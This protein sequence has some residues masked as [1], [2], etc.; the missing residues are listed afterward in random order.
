MSARR[1]DAS[2]RPHHPLVV[3]QPEP[4]AN[5]QFLGAPATG[6]AVNKDGQHAAI[7]IS[8]ARP[9]SRGQGPSV[10]TWQAEEAAAAR[11]SDQ[12]GGPVSASA[13]SKVGGAPL[14]PKGIAPAAAVQESIDQQGSVR[15]A[16]AKARKAARRSRGGQKE[17]AR[18]SRRD[19][20]RYPSP[21]P[22]HYHSKG[23]SSS[24]NYGGPSGYDKSSG[25][26]GSGNYGGEE[27]S[28]AG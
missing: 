25:Y 12:Q 21:G 1:H 26:N 14:L 20:G 28:F 2:F 7:S 13:A 6:V 19:E 18:R 11:P 9:T 8:P 27:S 4:A 24:G 17:Q 3:I 23:G 16:S 22:E 10:S 5:P 15:S